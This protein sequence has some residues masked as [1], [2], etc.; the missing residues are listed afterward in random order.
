[1]VRKNAA[2][3]SS[4]EIKNFCDALVT[5]NTRPYGGYSIYD[6][7]VAIH[8][9]VVARNAA[10]LDIG[11]GGHNSS[12]FLSWHREYL[13]RFELELKKI[14][15]CISLPYWDWSSGIESDTDNVFTEDFM[16]TLG[17][18]SNNN[19]IDSN[20]FGDAWV[21][22]DFH[23]TNG[24]HLRREDTF[25]RTNLDADVSSAMGKTTY[26]EFRSRLES[27]HNAVHIK[28]GFH[29]RNMTS[30]NDPIFFLHHANIDRIWAEWQQYHPN[31][32]GGSSVDGSRDTEIDDVMW[33]WSGG[34]VSSTRTLGSVPV[35]DIIP[36]YSNRDIV[37]NA[38]VLNY[39][40]NIDQYDNCHCCNSNCKPILTNFTT[41]DNVNI[42]NLFNNPT[43]LPIVESYSIN[44]SLKHD[45]N[46]DTMYVTG[47]Y[48]LEHIPSAEKNDIY[49]VMIQLDDAAWLD[50]FHI[51]PFASISAF[52][53]VSNDTI[54]VDQFRASEIINGNNKIPSMICAVADYSEH[55]DKLLR[56]SF[57]ATIIGNRREV[58]SDPGFDPLV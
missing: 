57:S 23:E 19:E 34:S 12:A 9:G 32:Y 54:A 20:Y 36:Q 43:S 48:P 53:N 56:L 25:L 27:P 14:D 16:G 49:G 37:R 52:R 1:M 15:P 31:I 4:T 24:T 13:Y 35:E 42:N 5:L 21:H 33:P 40:R 28:L 29:M 58:I 22:P 6:K 7:F 55:H 3:L 46:L 8:Y 39:Y 11:D 45:G 30:P 44:R 47:S 17:I 38:D 50:G 2:M 10:G 26:D 18:L 51:I 41:R